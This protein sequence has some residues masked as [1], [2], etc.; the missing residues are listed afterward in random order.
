MEGTQKRKSREKK[1]KERK[2]REVVIKYRQL[3]CFTEIRS[4]K[5]GD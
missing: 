5:N 4:R 2:S 3:L 1:K